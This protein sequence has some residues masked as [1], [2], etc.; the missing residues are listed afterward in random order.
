MSHLDSPRV[1]ASEKSAY[2]VREDF[3]QVFAK[4]G[5][6]LLR[7]SLQLTADVR[8]A[9]TCLTR[10]LGD[11]SFTTNIFKDRVQGWARRVVIRHAIR[12]TWR[13]TNDILCKRDFEFHLQPS[14]YSS[15]ALR[16]SIAILGLPVLDRLAFVIC[17]LERYSI[18]DCALLLKQT[19]QG[20]REAILRAIQQLTNEKSPLVSD[21]PKQTGG[22]SGV[23]PH[24]GNLFECS[25]GSILDHDCR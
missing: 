9:E 20:V 1:N 5:T 11:C 7:L 8:K 14:R 23:I 6:E 13:T 12:V 2:A 4:Q 22:M 24:V 16:E 25:C 17:V 10:A 18:L 3:E 21:G 15:D 19:P